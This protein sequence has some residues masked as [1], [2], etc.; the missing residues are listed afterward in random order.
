LT[1]SRL[2]VEIEQGGAG[3]RE[4]YDQGVDNRADQVDQHQRQRGEDQEK[5]QQRTSYTE[6]E[7]QRNDGPDRVPPATPDQIGAGSKGFPDLPVRE[8]HFLLDK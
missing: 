1:L 2:E 6:H 3:G 4:G 5:T 7:G 8:D